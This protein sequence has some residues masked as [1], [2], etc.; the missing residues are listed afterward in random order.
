MI[1]FKG[2]PIRLLPINPRYTNFEDIDFKNLDFENYS[3]IDIARELIK[4][5][6]NLEDLLELINA[7]ISNGFLYLNDKILIHSD[8]KN[9]N[10]YILEGNRRLLAV[11]LINKE[12]NLSD[13][14]D[15]K[16]YYSNTKFKEWE[17]NKNAIIENIKKINK[18]NIQ[19][20]W[21]LDVSKDSKE[22]IWKTIYSKHIGEQV[23]KRD[24]SRAKY[25]DDLLKLYKRFLATF[26]K[27]QALVELSK[28]FGKKLD[29]IKRDVKSAIWIIKSFDIYNEFHKDNPI[30]LKLMEV[31]GY[32]L[33]LSQ[34]LIVNG[35]EKTIRDIL[36][37]QIDDDKINILYD[38]KIQPNQLNKIIKF[39]VENSLNKKI[40]TREIKEEIYDK[41]GDVIGY[42]LSNKKSLNFVY[43]ELLDKEK[44]KTIKDFE[45]IKLQSLINLKSEDINVN[46][47]LDK[48]YDSKFI[49]SIK[50]TIRNDLK[51]LSNLKIF[52]E[53]EYPFTNVANTIRNIIDLFILEMVYRIKDIDA[54][55]KK[56]NLDG[57]S[58]MELKIIINHYKNSKIHDVNKV[59][60]IISNIINSNG[61]TE[62]S[63][64]LISFLEV[65]YGNR[66]KELNID[67]NQFES[68]VLRILNF[69]KHD[70]E[71]LS[72]FTLLNN[73]SHKPYYGFENS[74]NIKL[75][76]N[77]NIMF[78]TVKE[79]IKVSKIWEK[80]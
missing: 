54:F 25:F 11:K 42:T 77:L 35:R 10:Y 4:Y 50:Y 16:P 49:K 7:I 78:S 58:L 80:Q 46:E 62:I 37:I 36:G 59:T 67:I 19:E 55:G 44:N 43:N 24:W 45:K 52:D 27:E 48:D 22:L 20:A 40:T 5:E 3:E 69:K 38:N 51:T 61:V 1:E 23:G 63:D 65:E 68:F 41:L 76:D 75:I 21:F 47:F 56:F 31:S 8:I 71:I 39:L 66:L 30:D 17:N 15:D 60:G 26:D 70:K 34:K 29:I 14:V 13:I 28:L 12:I 57:G 79:F 32:E 53:D 18:I 73:L 6:G 33:V 2:L 64:F 9:K 72:N 74:N